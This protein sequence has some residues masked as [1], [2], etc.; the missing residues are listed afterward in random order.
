[1]KPLI[2]IN[3]KLYPEAVGKKGIQL[4]KK[5]SS[6]KSEKYRL[7]LAPSLLN[8]KETCHACRKIQPAISIY[9]QHADPVLAGARTGSISLGELKEM[10]VK[11]VLLNHSE[12]KRP[13]SIL[14]ETVKL[15]QSLNLKT[16][17]CASDTAD[18]KVFSRL[19]PDYIAYEPGK[20]IG[21]KVSVTSAKPKLI[22]KAVRVLKKRNPN[23]GLLVGAGVHS[24]ED[25]LKAMELGA[26]GALVGHAVPRAKEPQK[27]LK[28]MLS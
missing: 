28:K 18:I 20:L 10:G 4:A 8:L 22:R 5:L 1:M 3:F 13:Y 21:G 24:R 16:I 15:C 17:V 23:I 6:V 7:A 14:K 27:F 9:A 12:R 19:N 2:L 26:E 11:G 25:L